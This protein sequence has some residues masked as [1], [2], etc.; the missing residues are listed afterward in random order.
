M[1]TRKAYRCVWTSIIYFF[2]IVLKFLQ[3]LVIMYEEIF[4]AVAVEGDVLLPKPFLDF[5][6]KGV[7]RWKSPASEMFFR[8]AKHVKVQ[9]GQ[10]GAIR[11]WPRSTNGFGTRSL[12]VPPGLGKS[13]RTL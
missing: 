10:V 1:E 5:G 12:L 6:F 13:P 11:W 9:E 8:F 4:Q 7:V 3:A 2:L